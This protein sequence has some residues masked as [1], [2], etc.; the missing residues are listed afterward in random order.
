MKPGGKVLPGCI[1]LPVMIK[2]GGYCGICLP[3]A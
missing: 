2:E 1:H 3:Q